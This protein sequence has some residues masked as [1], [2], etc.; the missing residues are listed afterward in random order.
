[1]HI[2]EFTEYIYVWQNTMNN[3]RVNAGA[4]AHTIQQPL[5]IAQL[6]SDCPPYVNEPRVAAAKS[7]WCSSRGSRRRHRHGNKSLTHHRRGCKQK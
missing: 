3:L 2:N 1:M 6:A 5:L 7:L 4:A